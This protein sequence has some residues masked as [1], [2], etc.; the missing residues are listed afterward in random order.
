MTFPEYRAALLA[1]IV[2]A[3]TTAEL[4]ELARLHR[5]VHREC[6]RALFGGKNG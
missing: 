6:M 3:Q 4:D 2:A 1:A 5:R